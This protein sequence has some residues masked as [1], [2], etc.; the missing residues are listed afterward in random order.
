VRWRTPVLVTALIAG[1][2][3]TLVFMVV[4]LPAGLAQR[5]LA[6]QVPELQFTEPRGSVWNGSLN[7]LDGDL[8]LGRLHWGITFTSL[9]RLKPAVAAALRHDMYNAD[10]NLRLSTSHLIVTDLVASADLAKVLA[11]LGVHGIRISGTLDLDKGRF[12]WP[13]DDTGNV[14]WANPEEAHADLVL[15]RAEILL[16]Q[17]I[18]ALMIPP[19]IPLEGV[20]GT[21]RTS[22][23]SVKLNIYRQAETDLLF[24]ARLTADA[25]LHV[26]IRRR[27]L[28]I[29]RIP[30]IFKST[31][32]D[33]IWQTTILLPRHWKR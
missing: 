29:A 2:L 9:L 20:S 14:L 13:L 4:Q 17:K 18:L 30:W 5:L 16:D 32:D 26:E 21:L 27:L 6:A 24:H 23:E 10:W 19:A 11:G 7:I 31:P 15:S 12:R 3:A 33:A 28:D 8:Y 22:E 25:D 1:V